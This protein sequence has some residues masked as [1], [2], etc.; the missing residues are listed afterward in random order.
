MPT[1]DV[2]VWRTFFVDAARACIAAVPDDGVCAFF[3]TDVHDEGTWVDKSA[4]VIDAARAEGAAMLWHKI[5]LR[6]PVGTTTW[7]RPS[8]SHL[9]CFSRGVRV[10][11]QKRGPDVVENG[12][13]LWARGM[14]LRACAFALRQMQT[15]APSTTTMIDP[16]CGMGT[17]LAVANALGLDAIGVELNTK[18]A[19]RARANVAHDVTSNAAAPGRRSTR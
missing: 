10:D 9:L 11:L 1:R 2:G 19:A 5:V 15:L 8:Y 18:R 17:T 3:Q 12:A 13:T 16:F 7:G 4:L 14:G 6:V